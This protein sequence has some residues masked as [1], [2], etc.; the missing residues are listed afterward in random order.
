MTQS[1]KVLRCKML[2]LDVRT[3]DCMT[4]QK[5][6]PVV[7]TME[8]CALPDG[9]PVNLTETDCLCRMGISIQAML[10]EDCSSNSPHIDTARNVLGALS[11][12]GPGPVP[13]LGSVINMQVTFPESF[14]TTESAAVLVAFSL[15]AVACKNTQVS[16]MLIVGVTAANARDPALSK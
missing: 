15:L 16:G 12:T 11:G 10:T 7:P 8:S 6:L 9:Q 1:N 13:E 14:D 4:D 5:S 3:R 2:E